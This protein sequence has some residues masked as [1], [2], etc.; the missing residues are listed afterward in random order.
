MARNGAEKR[1]RDLE[2]DMATMK[3]HRHSIDRRMD[4]LGKGLEA[5][6]GL[7][8]KGVIALGVLVIGTSI[9][10]GFIAG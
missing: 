5:V 2:I 6:R 7:I 8:W 3:E 9:I 4:G 10:Q 1:I